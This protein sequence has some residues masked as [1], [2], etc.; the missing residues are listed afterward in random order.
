MNRSTL[1]RFIQVKNNLVTDRGCLS[2]NLNIT[3][4]QIASYIYINAMCQI[5]KCQ[6]AELWM[7]CTTKNSPGKG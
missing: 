4:S 5:L 7:T 2:K 6:T 1:F 3:M